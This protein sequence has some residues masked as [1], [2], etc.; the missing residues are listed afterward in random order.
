MEDIPALCLFCLDEIK[1]N[2]KCP[3]VI[4]CAC[5]FHCHGSCLE[6]WFEQ[7][8]Q[9]ECPICHRVSVPNP[10]IT[11]RDREIVIIHV[12]DPEQAERIRTMRS[13]EKCVA[14]CCFSLL[15]WWIFSLIIEYAF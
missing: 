3:N 12:Q 13:Q 9:M 10:I 15:F 4:G 8:R 2:Q 1:E 6:D 14:A 11:S 5:D 7:K